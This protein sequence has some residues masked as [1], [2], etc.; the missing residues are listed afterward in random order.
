MSNETI[1]RD[2]CHVIWTEGDL[3]RV[4]EFYTEDFKADYPRTDWGT[5]LEGISSLARGIRVQFPDYREQ[6]D[7]LISTDD[8]VVVRLTIKGT[9][10]GK[11][12]GIEPT[13]KA[14]EFRDMT[15]LR[16]RDGKICEQR[17][18]SDHF[19]IYQQMGIMS[20]NQA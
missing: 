1:V 19:A 9:H 13:G 20:L 3:S 4:G 7:E 2:A 18:L 11:A 15:I 17:G 16:I 10:L 8:I 12:D 6:I 14:V 5:G